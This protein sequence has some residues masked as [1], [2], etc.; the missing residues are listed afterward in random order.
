MTPDPIPDR[1]I[2][3]QLVGANENLNPLLATATATTSEAKP[4]ANPN[5]RSRNQPGCNVRPSERHGN[6]SRKRAQKYPAPSAAASSPTRK[7]S[8]AMNTDTLADAY[9]PTAIRTTRNTVAIR[10]VSVMKAP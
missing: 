2:V 10:K 7:I 8:S 4:I 3:D 1:I 5:T 6:P 9:G